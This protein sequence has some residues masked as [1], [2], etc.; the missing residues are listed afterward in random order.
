M[1]GSPQSISETSCEP[2]GLMAQYRL[3]EYVWAALDDYFAS[4]DGN[5]T[6]NVYALVITEV[7]RPLLTCVLEYCEG[8]QTRAAQLLGINRATLRKKLREHLL[9]DGS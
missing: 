5:S 3:A 4:L 7:E 2:T 8:N 1:S 6:G 9:V